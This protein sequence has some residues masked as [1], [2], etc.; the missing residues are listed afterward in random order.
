MESLQK[1]GGKYCRL[2]DE[3]LLKNIMLSTGLSVLEYIRENGELDND[4]IC[5]FI[6]TNAAAIIDDTIDHLSTTEEEYD[7]EEEEEEEE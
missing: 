1:M 4:D 5:E 7:D 6:E 2:Y 3:H